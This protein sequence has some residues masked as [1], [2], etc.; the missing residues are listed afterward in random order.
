MKSSFLLASF[1]L[2]SGALVSAGAGCVAKTVDVGV[3]QNADAG[4]QP[5][6][7]GASSG[8]VPQ[9]PPGTPS[10]RAAQVTAARKA[11]SAPHGPADPVDTANAA[12]TRIKGAWLSCSEPGLPPPYNTPGGVFDTDDPI[13]H[14]LADDGVG[15]LVEAVGIN[16]AATFAVPL[17]AD[18]AG[19][20]CITDI[21]DITCTLLLFGPTR[22]IDL[23]VAFE[24]GPR[25]MLFGSDAWYVPLG[26]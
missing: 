15:G 3:R 11:C 8:P 22:N 12:L 14:A 1:F 6:P 4:P 9:P 10:F 13:Y 19:D 20:T 25:R 26:P 17:L 5:A 24:T 18:D 21:N 2:G 7:D 23:S 16:S